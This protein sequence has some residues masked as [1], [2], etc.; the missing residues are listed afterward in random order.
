M[1]VV[2]ENG[3]IKVKSAYNAEFVNGAKMLQGKWSAPYWCFPEENEQEV[4]ELLLRIYGENGEEQERVSVIVDVSKMN[5]GSIYLEGILLATRFSRDCAV[6]L[7]ENVILVSGGFPE[8]GGSA[9]CPMC[10]PEEGTKLKIKGVPL[11][12][13]ERIKE[14][15]AL[16]DDVAQRKER[17]EAEKAR[18]LARLAEIEKE[19]KEF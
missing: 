11:A 13:Y 15:V 14:K 3:K 16:C 5:G 6:K 8:R 18:L 2:M 1:K 17:L 9:K 4:R 19:L 12:L 7:A 10:N